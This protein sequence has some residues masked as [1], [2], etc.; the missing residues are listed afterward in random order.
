[1]CFDAVTLTRLLKR[2]KPGGCDGRQDRRVAIFRSGVRCSLRCVDFDQSLAGQE[3]GGDIKFILLMRHLPPVRGFGGEPD[4]KVGISG[5]VGISA[6]Q[7]SGFRN[8]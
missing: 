4:V 3:V 8:R 6:V 7:V 1:M 5:N 2:T